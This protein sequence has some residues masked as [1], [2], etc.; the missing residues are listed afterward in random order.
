[1]DFATC[2]QVWATAF[3]LCW[4]VG[5]IYILSFKSDPLDLN[6]WGDYV[7]GVSAPVAFLWLVVAVFLQSSELKAQRSELSLTR[8]ELE[9]QRE[10][11]KAQAAE[12]ARQ[13]DFIGLQCE[14]MREEHDETKRDAV[15]ERT[16]R[17]LASVMRRYQHAWTVTHGPTP[18]FHIKL[19][20][21]DWTD[22]LFIA[23]TAQH[24]RNNSKW[25]RSSNDLRSSFRLKY[26]R[27]F[28]RLNNAVV[29]AGDALK[30]SEG[31]NT[32][33]IHALE[34]EELAAFVVQM[35]SSLSLKGFLDPS[36]QTP[37]TDPEI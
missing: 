1:M 8:E 4:I 34:I 12:A 35:T 2:V 20:E 18:I 36:E 33:R 7:A 21:A 24:L 22:E 31:F 11:M 26:P 3:T 30:R 13:A 10:V 37:G 32:P 27:E 14:I 17:S 19:N 16:V 28:A 6:E 29:V 15:Y 23:R 25:L 5:A 9:L